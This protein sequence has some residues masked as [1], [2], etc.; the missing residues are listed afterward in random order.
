MDCIK[1]FQM[2]ITNIKLTDSQREILI[3]GHRT[4]R[5]RLYNDAELSTI[6]VSDFLQGSYRRNTIVRPQMGKNADVDIVVVTR[7]SEVEYSPVMAMKKFEPFLNKHYPGKW[8]PQSRSFGIAL[9][10]VDLDLVIT[11]APNECDIDSIYKSAAVTSQDELFED[12]DWRLNKFWIDSSMRLTD[13]ARGLLKEAAVTQEWQLNPLK[14]PDRDKLRWD[15][16]HPLAQMQWTIQK[17]SRTNGLF[18]QVV[19]AF[20]WWRLNKYPE[21]PKPKGFPLERLVGECCPD[22]INTIGEGFYLTMARFIETFQHLYDN[23]VKPAL[24]DYGVTNHDVLE[25]TTNSEFRK[26][27]EQV[28]SDIVIAANA[29]KSNDIISSCQY[30]RSLFG[31]KFPIPSGTTEGYIPPTRPADPDNNVRFA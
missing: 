30:W 18:I 14:I 16:T 23:G 31:E 27:F 19:R 10:N 25:R 26:M 21:H 24:K 11:S 29:L 4:L 17:N 5:E 22:G 13:D 3:N 28:K 20:K 12:S 9:S 2:F 15:D 7:L 1:Q 8:V 6:I